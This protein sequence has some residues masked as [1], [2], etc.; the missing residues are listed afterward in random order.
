MKRHSDWYRAFKYTYEWEL[1]TVLNVSELI[2]GMITH[3]Q[4]HHALDAILQL[5]VQDS[6][7]AAAAAAAPPATLGTTMPDAELNALVALVPEI[8]KQRQRSL[9]DYYE[10]VKKLKQHRSMQ[11]Q[12]M[13]WTTTTTKKKQTRE[14][15][16]GT[17]EMVDMEYVLGTTIEVL[18][19]KENKGADP[20]NTGGEENGATL[21][22]AT[23]R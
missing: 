6:S 12:S 20:S 15:Q 7:A 13:A 11:Q 18:P 2:H 19:T 16:E 5:C 14:E 1:N 21:G 4:S 23:R 3:D 10:R 22:R 17:E 8:Y 9:A